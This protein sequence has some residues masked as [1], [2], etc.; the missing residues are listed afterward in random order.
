MRTANPDFWEAASLIAA[1][2]LREGAP[3]GEGITLVVGRD[4]RRR[5][6]TTQAKTR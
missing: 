5:A 6:E 4:N 3:L 1:R 2:L